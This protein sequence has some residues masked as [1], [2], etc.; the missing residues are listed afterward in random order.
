MVQ[1][2]SNDDSD[3]VAKLLRDNLLI[4]AESASSSGS[5]VAHDNDQIV[6]L[7]RLAEKLPGDAVHFGTGTSQEAANRCS[8]PRFAL[9]SP[10]SSRCPFSRPFIEDEDICGPPVSREEV[11]SSNDDENIHGEDVASVLVEGSASTVS[12]VYVLGTSSSPSMTKPVKAALTLEE[13]RI[14]R[15]S[16]AT[17]M[18]TKDQKGLIMYLTIFDM[19]PESK[20]LFRA[21]KA[22]SEPPPVNENMQAHATLAFSMMCEAFCKWDDPVEVERAI[23]FFKA[24][25]GRHLKYGIDA[26]DF[27]IFRMG[28]MKS[29][30]KAFGENWPGA[31]EASW[32]A[33]FDMLENM[34]AAGMA[35]LGGKKTIPEHAR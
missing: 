20:K 11:E 13:G 34:A 16:Y 5:F 33:A 4:N 12:I 27:P 10:A 26:D 6:L 19:V 15:E 32:S 21:L 22:S 18:D 29:L 24:L 28:L 35:E 7:N 3:P 17:I 1:A 23:P 25:G 8:M 30:R 9:S 31:M 14:I 2:A